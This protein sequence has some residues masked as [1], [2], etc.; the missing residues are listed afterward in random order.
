MRRY[1]TI[2]VVLAFLLFAWGALAQTSTSGHQH[3]MQTTT[4]TTTT[5]QQTTASGAERSI[6]GCL[7]KEGSDFFL[8][9]ARGNPIELQASTG[10][11][12]SEHEGH[13]VKV[14]GVE[15]SLSAS[16]A[17]A[18]SGTGGAAG[19]ATTTTTTTPSGAQSSTSS[20]SQP[21]GG[22]A[23]GNAG[24]ASGTGNDL[25]RLANQQLTVA[26][27][28]HIADTCPVNWN[29]RVPTKSKTSKY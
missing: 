4:T 29:S 2:A 23:A 10:Q 14:R 28:D 6:E 17:A 26:N 20:V 5:T 24:A 12:L 11:N 13:K 18:T 16:N 15:S 1:M 21:A 3:D 22:T 25:H 27:L 19:A 7:A 9:P 8:I